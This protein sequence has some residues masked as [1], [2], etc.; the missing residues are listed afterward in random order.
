M[1][2]Q[3]VSHNANKLPIIGLTHLSHSGGRQIALRF[4]YIKSLIAIV[5]KLPGCA[6]GK[7]HGCWYVP[8]TRV[9]L[10][11][12]AKLMNDEQARVVRW[13]GKWMQ[14]K[15]YSEN[16]IMVYRDMLEV[17]FTF[18][19]DKPVREVVNNDVID[20]NS[21]WIIK[22]GRSESYQQQAVNA[23]K[24][25][26]GQIEGHKLKVDKLERVKLA[27]KLPIVLSLEEV[28]ALFE[29]YDNLKHKT[30]MVLIY[31]CGLRRSELLNLKLTDID[32]SCMLLY[33]RLGKGN[34]DRQVVLPESVLQRLDEY[35]KEYKTKTWLFEGQYGGQYSGQSLQKVM[36]AG[37]KKVKATLHSL[38]HSYATHL[39]EKGTDIVLI[40]KLLGVRI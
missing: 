35:W 8:N 38:R 3:A 30:M 15:G 40:Q 18:V 14:S 5:K 23:I 11:P 29:S 9:M 26:Y 37:I 6:R 33:V 31:A 39:H 12:I 27:R 24:L 16:A 28:K 34:K 21:D 1:S 22:T 17:F 7:T 10:K 4:D 32:R 20:F 36:K 25:F 13:F 2:L 19:G